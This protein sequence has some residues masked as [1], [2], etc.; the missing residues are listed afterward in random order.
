MHQ[1]LLNKKYFFSPT[2]PTQITLPLYDGVTGVGVDELNN[3]ADWLIYPNPAKSDLTIITDF[4]ENYEISLFNIRGQ[5]MLTKNVNTKRSNINIES[6]TKGVYFIK[7]KTA[8]G[9]V[10]TQ[11]M[12][13]N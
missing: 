6:L 10:S 8:S 9:I 11:K 12:V 4:E 13:K 2:Q 7:I 3:K 5:V 1:E